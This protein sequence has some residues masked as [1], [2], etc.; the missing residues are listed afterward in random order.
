MVKDTYL[1]TLKV[2]KIMPNLL[3]QL[4]VCFMKQLYQCTTEMIVIYHIR[5]SFL[6]IRHTLSQQ[7]LI[8]EKNYTNIVPA[9]CGK[10]EFRSNK[11][12]LESFFQSIS[13]TR[14]EATAWLEALQESVED[15]TIP[16]SFQHF[17]R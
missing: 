8:F 4:N 1:N 13:G 15:T 16:V 11:L 5:S 12:Q 17:F 7:C 14:N 10:P 3:L 6:K 2:R 9:E